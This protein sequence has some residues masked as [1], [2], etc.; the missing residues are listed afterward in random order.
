MDADAVQHEDVEI[1]PRLIG[2]LEP[3]PGLRP[4]QHNK[5]MIDGRSMRDMPAGTILA[6]SVVLDQNPLRGRDPPQTSGGSATALA[7]LVTLHRSLRKLVETGLCKGHRYPPPARRN[8]VGQVH[9]QQVEW[10]NDTRITPSLDDAEGASPPSPNCHAMARL[11]P[12]RPIR[13]K[14][15][16]LALLAELDGRLGKVGVVHL[17]RGGDQPPQR[18]RHRRGAAPD[19]ED[20]GLR[21]RRRLEGCRDGLV[22]S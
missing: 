11:R 19:V 20:L 16:L 6:V 7:P 1:W 21:A 10:M 18:K 3:N 17:P 12:R 22:E 4:L 8:E 13:G 5:V 15:L 14:E 9:G 2:L